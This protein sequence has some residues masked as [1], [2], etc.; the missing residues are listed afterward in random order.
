M[1]YKPLSINAEE[2]SFKVNQV[3]IKPET[4]INLRPIFK[5]QVRTADNDPSMKLLILSMSVL[6]SEAEPKPFDLTITY[7]ASYKLFNFDGES[8]NE[9]FLLR[10]TNDLYTYLRTTALTVTAAANIMPFMLPREAPYFPP[11]NE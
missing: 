11:A 1:N 3:S 6:T 5:R 8:D 10:A 2:I 9:E 4:K 7:V